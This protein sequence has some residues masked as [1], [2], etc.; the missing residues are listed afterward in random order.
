MYKLIL[1]FGALPRSLISLFTNV[2]KRNIVCAHQCVLMNL[3]KIYLRMFEIKSAISNSYNLFLII[4][5]VHDIT[6]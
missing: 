5:K 2:F 4:N 3:V 1:A 6:V